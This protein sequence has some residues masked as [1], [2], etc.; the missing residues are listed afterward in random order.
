MVAED[1]VQSG[2]GKFYFE[3]KSTT[4]IFLDLCQDLFFSQ[5]WAILDDSIP[6]APEDYRNFQEKNN[7][8]LR[9]YNILPKH[10]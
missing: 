3:F 6:L 7:V 8:L 5:D 1:P 10:E 2:I 4:N 9:N